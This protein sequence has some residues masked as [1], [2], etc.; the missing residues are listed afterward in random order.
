MS[1][2]IVF[3]KG[4]AVA[5]GRAQRPP[6][7]LADLEVGDAIWVAA[8][9]GAKWPNAQIRRYCM[10]TGDTITTRRQM[11]DGKPGLL[12]SRLEDE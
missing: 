3:I 4:G 10:G 11:K 7:P 8:E 12:I 9:P 2:E 5:R 1:D 6:I